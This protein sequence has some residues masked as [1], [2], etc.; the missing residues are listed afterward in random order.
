MNPCSGSGNQSVLTTSFAPHAFRSGLTT[1]LLL[2]LAAAVPMPI[3]SRTTSATPS[4]TARVRR[5]CLAILTPFPEPMRPEPSWVACRQL[6]C[7]TNA[8]P[9]SLLVPVLGQLV[10][11]EADDPEGDDP[12][13]AA[14]RE[15]AHE[16]I[17]LQIGAIEIEQTPKPRRPL[18]E[19]EL[20][21]D[22]ADHRE[23]GGDA[24]P[25]ED[26]GN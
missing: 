26:V 12:E 5:L 10:A 15:A 8:L 19:E 25:D 1:L 13:A 11:D 21:D 18:P 6:R 20:A 17:G 24:Q 9:R 2:L 23:S 14:E 7:R 4:P 16:Q 3:A 22:R